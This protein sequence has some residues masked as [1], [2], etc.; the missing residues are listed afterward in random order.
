MIEITL[1]IKIFLVFFINKFWI[2]QEGKK[3]MCTFNMRARTRGGLN[4]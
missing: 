2:L 4:F 1:L 3:L